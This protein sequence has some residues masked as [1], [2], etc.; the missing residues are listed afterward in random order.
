[1]RAQIDFCDVP[2][3]LPS[4]AIVIRDVGHDK[5]CPSITN[6]AEAVV[7]RVLYIARQMGESSDCRIFYYDSDGR[8]DELCHDGIRFTGF[9][10]G[11]KQ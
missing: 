5:G 9:K 6:D 7:M 2:P 4:T 3:G 11:P 8:L 1:M 10:P